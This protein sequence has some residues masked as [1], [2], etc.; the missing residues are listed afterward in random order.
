M[1]EKTP[2]IKTDRDLRDYYYELF[3]LLAAYFAVDAEEDIFDSEYTIKHFCDVNHVETIIKTIF[4]AN[5]ILEMEP[6]PR[7]AVSW[8]AGGLSKDPEEVR[9]WLR[10]VIHLLNLET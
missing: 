3:N 5:E 9:Q 7:E 6:F 10:N 2:L 8:A 1:I 4:Q